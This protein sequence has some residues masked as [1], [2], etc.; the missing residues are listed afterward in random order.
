MRK[1]AYLTLGLMTILPISVLA[2]EADRVVVVPYS[3]KFP[4]LPHPSYE[5]DRK[6][7]KAVIQN[8]S[9]NIGYR[10]TWDTNLNKDY[11]DDNSITVSRNGDCNCVRD[12]GILYT[13]GDVPQDE[14][15]NIDVQVKNLCTQQ[16]TYGTFQ[17]Y[18]YDFRPSNNASKWVHPDA[19]QQTVTKEQLEI[20]TQAAIQEGLWYI[21]RT[22]SSISGSGA[23]MTGRPSDRWGAP[24]ELWALLINGHLPA[25]PPSVAING[26]SDCNNSNQCHQGYDFDGDGEADYG[27]EECI[28][29]ECLPKGFKAANDKRFN[30][31]PYAET[32]M[33]LANFMATNAGLYNIVEGQEGNQNGWSAPGQPRTIAGF[34][35]PK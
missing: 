17:M 3:Q 28:S 21:H 30:T 6:S 24:I 15:R 23:T 7:L 4:E 11:S 10:V 26:T 25:Y 29:N 33:R 22:L 27:E 16:L 31:D 20:M 5:G 9:C 2:Q 19:N 13:V 18:I 35:A 14:E 1:L 32:A 34:P 8:A 12:A